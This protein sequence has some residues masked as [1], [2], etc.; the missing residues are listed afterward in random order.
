M[1]IEMR[2]APAESA[3]TWRMWLAFLLL[4][5]SW[6]SRSFLYWKIWDWHVRYI[7]PLAP[8][9][10]LAQGFSLFVIVA[11][12]RALPKRNA[13]PDVLTTTLASCLAPWILL[14]VAWFIHALQR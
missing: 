6:V 4:P 3:P 1:G 14:V 9:L 12:T 13:D 7:F 10:T 2:A 5:V 8:E 11:V